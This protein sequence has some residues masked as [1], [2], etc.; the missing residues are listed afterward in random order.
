MTT[1]CRMSRLITC[2]KALDTCEPPQSDTHHLLVTPGVSGSMTR[3]VL[4]VLDTLRKD[5]FDSHFEWPPGL[6]FENA[7]S[8][9]H[10]IV[11]SHASLF[12]GRYG[13][14]IGSKVNSKRLNISSPVLSEELSELGV[15]TR[16]FSVQRPWIFMS[17][18]STL[19]LGQVYIASLLHV[20]SFPL[21]TNGQRHVPDACWRLST[22]S[23]YIL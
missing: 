15:S 12:T 22:S 4:A 20:D 11:P 14:E 21:T 3:V 5:A 10:W 16:A 6:R 8:T 1:C 19:F 2:W 23:V 17:Q 9:S 7:W 13:S 18:L